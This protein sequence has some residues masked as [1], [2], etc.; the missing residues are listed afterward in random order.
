MLLRIRI[1]HYLIVLGCIQLMACS[2]E[3]PQQIGPKLPGRQGVLISNEGTF[4]QGNASVYFVHQT[5]DSLNSNSD[6]FKS[7]NKRP[8]GD[9]CQSMVLIQNKLWLVVNNSG[10]IEVV[11]PATFQSEQV[12]SGLKSPR[13]ALEINA[14]KAYVSDLY[15]GAIHIIDL[16]TLK[17]TGA[18]PC[19]GWTEEM[20][21]HEQK[22]WVSCFDREYLYILDPVADKR[23]DSVKVAYGGSSLFE[24]KSGMLWLLCSGDA[25]KG[26]TGGLFCIDMK[27][28]QIIR[29]WLFKDPGFNPVRLCQNPLQDSL[30]YLFKGVYRLSKDAGDLPVTPIIPQPKGASF[31]SMAVDPQTGMLWVSDAVDYQSRGYV[32]LFSPSG[33]KYKSYQV[34]V[35]PGGFLFR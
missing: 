9:V 26:K 4:M 11:D 21:L 2:D 31:Y 10:K 7:A 22:V 14:E 32:S 25:Q 24:D 16:R 30:Y 3:K 6:L 8:L 29:Q 5:Y 18:I 23:I 34:G 28:A 13:Y 27:K 20:V 35:I 19:G 1:L 33:S 15:A 12:I 17:K